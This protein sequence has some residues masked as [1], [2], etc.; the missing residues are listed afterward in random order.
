LEEPHNQGVVERV[1]ALGNR[2]QATTARNSTRLRTYGTTS[3]AISGRIVP[4]TTK[5]ISRRTIR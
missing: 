5:S 1:G 3:R 2:L 4:T